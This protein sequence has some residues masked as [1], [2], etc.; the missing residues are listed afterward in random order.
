MDNSD[1]STITIGAADVDDLELDTINISSIDMSKY[2]YN[3]S[4]PSSYSITTGATGSAGSF[5]TSS[6][7]NGM[8]WSTASGM[9]GSSGSLDVIG[10][11]SFSGDIKWKGRSLG[12]LLT[13]I[14]DRLAILAEPDPEKLAKFAAL[15]KAYDNYKLLERLIGD[16]D[17]SNSAE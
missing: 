15:K 7:S 1:E 12:K 4:P 9:V 3:Y 10:D 17:G 13:S 11:A 8:N 16:D 6:G 2:T 5:L 14:E